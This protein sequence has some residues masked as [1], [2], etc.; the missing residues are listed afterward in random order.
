MSPWTNAAPVG[1]VRGRGPIPAEDLHPTSHA[2]FPLEM[3]R[4]TCQMLI[5]CVE[6]IREQSGQSEAVITLLSSFEWQDLLLDL[7]QDVHERSIQRLWIAL[8]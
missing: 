1:S 6:P 5:V 2:V 3:L 8:L 4:S 7:F